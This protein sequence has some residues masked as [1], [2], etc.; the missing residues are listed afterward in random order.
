MGE[1]EGGERR[2]ESLTEGMG[3]ERRW[4]S[5]TGEWEERGGGSS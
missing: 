5:L 3:G 1:W 4:E 2:W